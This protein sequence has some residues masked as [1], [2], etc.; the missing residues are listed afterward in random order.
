MMMEN[1]V[2]LPFLNMCNGC[3][4]VRAVSPYW[5]TSVTHA[6]EDFNITVI[7]GVSGIEIQ[8]QLY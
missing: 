5:H 1:D 4:P 2:P 6:K 8:M 3:M 7:K